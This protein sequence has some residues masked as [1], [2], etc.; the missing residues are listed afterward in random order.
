MCIACELRSKHPD[1]SIAGIV[2]VS[3]RARHFDA[4]FTATRQPYLFSTCRYCAPQCNALLIG[5]HVVI[6]RR[7]HPARRHSDEVDFWVRIAAESLA[8]AVQFRKACVETACFV[9][10]IVF[11][12]ALLDHRSGFR[13]QIAFL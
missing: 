6:P 11:A 7:F 9:C 3:G 10:W 8:S 5:G 1:Q 13:A 4:S 12:S 2:I